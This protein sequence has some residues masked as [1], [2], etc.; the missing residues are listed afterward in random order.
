MIFNEKLVLKIV[1]ELELKF[2][3]TREISEKLQLSE[4]A[5]I[6]LTLGKPRK[7]TSTIKFS[8]TPVFTFF[9]IHSIN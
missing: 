1:K 7:R 5:I 2:L 8:N 9:L 6:E 4:R 3:S